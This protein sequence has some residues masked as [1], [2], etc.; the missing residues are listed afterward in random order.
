M[1]VERSAL[2]I[3]PSLWERVGVRET[4][5]ANATYISR[6]DAGAMIVSLSMKSG[7]LQNPLGIGHSAR[8]GSV[9]LALSTKMPLLATVRGKPA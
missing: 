3:S 8:T 2:H 1:K 7:Q 9:S 5:M 4:I 6:G